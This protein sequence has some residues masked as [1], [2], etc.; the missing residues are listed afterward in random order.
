MRYNE[1]LRQF[2]KRKC[3]KYCRFNGID[4]LWSNACVSGNSL[5]IFVGPR[6][7]LENMSTLLGECA[8]V[9]EIHYQET[10]NIKAAL[11]PNQRMTLEQAMDCF[12]ENA[13]DQ[14]GPQPSVNLANAFDAIA[15]DMLDQTDRIDR[16][17]EM[18]RWNNSILHAIAKQLNIPPAQLAPPRP[19]KPDEIN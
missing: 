17:D 18:C 2:V 6:A 9:S 11:D 13:D 8:D 7:F 4:E 3:G 1:P 15:N 10:D 14:F 16:V 5:V 12:D 19:A